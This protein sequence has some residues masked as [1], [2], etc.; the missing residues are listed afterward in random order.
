V[1]WADAARFEDATRAGDVVAVRQCRIV[2]TDGGEWHFLAD[3]VA[4]YRRLAAVLRRT[5][6]ERDP[7]PGPR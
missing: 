6:D 3:Y 7:P 4:G 5:M 2:L 1:S